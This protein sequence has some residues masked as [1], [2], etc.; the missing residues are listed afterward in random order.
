[1]MGDHLQGQPRSNGT[2]E[3]SRIDSG[4]SLRIT[5]GAAW[6]VAGGMLDQ[7]LTVNWVLYHPTDDS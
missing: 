6:M 3:C 1:M 4:A 7:V 2:E 5:L